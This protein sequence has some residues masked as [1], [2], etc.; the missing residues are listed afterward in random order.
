LV[1]DLTE[2]WDGGTRKKRKPQEGSESGTTFDKISSRRSKKGKTDPKQKEPEQVGKMAQQ[3]TTQHRE[4][5]NRKF[6]GGFNRQGLGRGR[7][8]SGKRVW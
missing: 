7:K 5:E 3:K 6:A 2:N 1:G 4:K 8:R